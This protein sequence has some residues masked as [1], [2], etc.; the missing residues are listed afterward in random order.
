MEWVVGE[1]TKMGCTVCAVLCA[2]CMCT[3]SDL[4]GFSRKSASMFISIVT[5]IVLLLLH[6]GRAVQNLCGMYIYVQY[7]HVPWHWRGHNTTVRLAVRCRCFAQTGAMTFLHVFGGW[8]RYACLS[9]TH[10]SWIA[11]HLINGLFGACLDGEAR[12]AVH[13]AALASDKIH[14]MCVCVCVAA[15]PHFQQHEAVNMCNRHAQVTLESYIW[16]CSSL[17][18]DKGHMAHNQKYQSDAH[19]S[20][21]QGLSARFSADFISW[22]L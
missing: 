3:A 19:S 21:Q 7:I 5:A 18:D 13:T 12:R 16:N 4:D 9:S 22:L 17:F 11:E 8:R 1:S 10:F 20:A 14:L 6:L 15:R 2:V